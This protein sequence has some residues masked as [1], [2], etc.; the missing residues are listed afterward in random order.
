MFREVY[1]TKK[2]KRILKISKEK[3]QWKLLF[4]M[5]NN[6]V[7]Q[8]GSDPPILE[9]SDVASFLYFVFLPYLNKILLAVFDKKS[10]KS[11]REIYIILG[12]IF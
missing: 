9:L 6:K 12:L 5:K 10:K 8:I 4:P 2:K 3:V 11:L 1:S 7:K